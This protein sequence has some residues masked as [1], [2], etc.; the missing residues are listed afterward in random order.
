[1]RGCAFSPRTDLTDP[2]RKKLVLVVIDGLTPEVLARGLD[3]GRLPALAAL[4]E[5]G[6]TGRGTSVFPSLTPVCLTSIATGAFPDVHRIPHL[7]WYHRGEG[8]VVEYGS[9]FSAMRAAG[10]RRSIRD[11]VFGL[12][13]EHLSP[14][15]V[16]VFEALEDGG[17]DPAAINFTCYR[18][19]TRHSIRLPAL[20][21]R[22]RWYE[23]VLG[24]KHFFFFNVFES[25]RTG[26]GLAVR[27]RLEGSIDEYA[28]DVGRWLVTRDAFDF[29]VFYLP[30]YD[31]A[32]HIAG[33][34]ESLD[35]L[36]RSDRAVGLL[37]EA[38]DGGGDFLE[39]YAVVVCSDHG[40]TRV[41]R[42]A[43]LQDSF[44]ADE[45]GVLALASNRAGM[46]Y[47]LGG[48][49]LDA[50]SLAE[51]LDDQPA[52]D[53]VLFREDGAAVARREGA[54]T[55][56]ALEGGEW[57]VEG[58]ESVL[59]SERYPNGLE[60]AWR[61][62]LGPHAG[63]V[64]VSAAEGWEFADLGGRHHLGGGSH[65]SLL[66]GDSTVPLV[67][68]GF[69]EPPFPPDPGITDLAPL[70]LAHFGLVAPASMRRPREAARA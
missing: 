15:A 31:Y 16:T 21:R 3:E 27:S 4:A 1:M 24:P 48:C 6:W 58:D 20:A 23:S 44:P 62:L 49:R 69:D 39:R 5:A 25:E 22:N 9:S 64:L 33:P 68:A 51:R 59:D 66:A 57:R 32:S 11:T 19:R 17:L 63:D 10:T 53:V 43:R 14:E 50:R 38:G 18:G 28:G 35:A 30:D 41:E 65:G 29:L 42:L 54:E 40:Q 8:R 12:S 34:E 36:E 52:A 7:V 26:A 47:R 70:A 61:A 45:P 55:R 37:L 60:R 46:V 13:G 56:F 2:D 67:A